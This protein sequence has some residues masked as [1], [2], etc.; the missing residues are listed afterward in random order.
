MGQKASK[1]KRIRFCWREIEYPKEAYVVMA[2]TTEEGQLGIGIP[3]YKLY[4][5]FELIKSDV[6]ELAEGVRK[7]PKMNMINE[8]LVAEVSLQREYPLDKKYWITEGIEFGWWNRLA[9]FTKVFDKSSLYQILVTP[10]VR[11]RKILLRAAAAFYRGADKDI[12]A[13]MLTSDWEVDESAK[14]SGIYFVDRI[15]GYN[16]ITG[17]EIIRE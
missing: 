14:T 11:K 5:D 4:T 16:W 7:E 2:L 3:M 13:F 15:Y 12:E 8:L 17:K 10:I 6:K 9:M 1:E